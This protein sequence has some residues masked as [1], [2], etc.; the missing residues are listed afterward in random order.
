MMLIE[1]YEKFLRVFESKVS[2]YFYMI[3]KGGGGCL[4]VVYGEGMSRE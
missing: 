3:M 1:S 4:C 2:R